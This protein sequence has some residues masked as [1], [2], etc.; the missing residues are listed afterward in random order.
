[1]AVTIKEIAQKSGVSRGTVDRVLNHRGNVSAQ[2]ERLVTQVATEM[3][4]RPNIAG[5]ALAARKKNFTIGVILC[6]E[7]NEFFDDVLDGINRAGSESA[8]YGVSVLI[9]TTKGYEVEQQLKIIEELRPQIHFLII[10]AI[11]DERIVRIIN[12]L[13]EDNIMVITINTDVKNSKRICHVG[14]NYTKSGET[15]G[16]MMGLITG[17]KGKV[18]IASGSRKI[19]GHSERVMG[20]TQ[21]CKN[22]YSE[23]EIVD[24][25]ETE[26]DNRVA[27]ENTKSLLKK[28][29][30]IEAIYIVAAGFSGVCKAIK[31]S[32]RMDVKVIACDCTQTMSSL[33]RNGMVQATI[34]Q[35]PYTQG[36]KSLHL[37]V[38][39]LVNGIS[40]YKDMYAVKNEIRILEN[41]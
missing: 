24:V 33:I 16:G 40:P 28:H 22:R 13:Y 19:L 14:S 6:S 34:C 12:K 17:G 38:Q 23:I 30:E 32:D 26:D 1:M 11:N 36:Y 27:Y 5:K 10:N 3:G 35:Q 4:Y 21:A 7:G 9:R 8:D 37:A 18:G 15:A 2:T 29:P 41:M 20:F 25:I 31:D 39:Y